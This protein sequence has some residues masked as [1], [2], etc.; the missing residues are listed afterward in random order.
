MDGW[1][2]MFVISSFPKML[3]NV[4]PRC[5]NLMDAGSQHP[6]RKTPSLP[7]ARLLQPLHP[8][9]AHHERSLQQKPL[10]S[11]DLNELVPTVANLPFCGECTGI[12]IFQ[13]GLHNR[14]EVG[15]RFEIE[16]RDVQYVPITYPA[17]ELEPEILSPYFVLE[18]ER[19]PYRKVP[20]DWSVLHSASTMRNGEASVS[21]LAA[22]K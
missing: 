15:A 10:R 9:M 14:S 5:Y 21:R 3:D 2:T 16:A 11:L 17:I 22:W 13:D 7:Y 18:S 20:A 6:R 1:E 8:M 4:Y 19:R 12:H